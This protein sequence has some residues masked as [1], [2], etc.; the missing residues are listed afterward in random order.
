MD[1]SDRLE[2]ARTEI[3]KSIVPFGIGTGFGLLT[4]LSEAYKLFSQNDLS[5]LKIAGVVLTL[6]ACGLLI[7]MIIL[8]TK[9]SRH[10]LTCA[11]LAIG[12]GAIRWVFIDKAFN[13]NIISIVLLG[14]FAGLLGQFIRWIR[15]GAL[16]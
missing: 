1:T 7:F 16:R 5:A 11:A 13:L 15:A 9:E 6:T 2:K 10:A 4:A 14:V 12:L 3:R 8:L